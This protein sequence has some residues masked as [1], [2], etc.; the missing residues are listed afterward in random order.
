[1]S[2]VA[3]RSDDVARPVAAP[4][5]PP[6]TVEQE[7]S[8]TRPTTDVLTSDIVTSDAATSDGRPAETVQPHE[9]DSNVALGLSRGDVVF[10]WVIG[11]VLLALTSLHLARLS[12]W[13]ARTVEVERLDPHDFSVRLD[14]NTANWVELSQLDAVGEVLARR[15]VDDREEHGPFAAVD[16]LRRVKGIGVKTLDKLRPLLKVETVEEAGT[17]SPE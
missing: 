12:G 14:L 15:I 4:P 9:D 2:D 5:V 11:C 7:T 1:M 16:D 17:R 10:A 6:E 13:G 8:S 3:T